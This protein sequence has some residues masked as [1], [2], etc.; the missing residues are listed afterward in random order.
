MPIRKLGLFGNP[1]KPEIAAA[2]AEAAAC[3]RRAGVPLL[4]ASDLAEFAPGVTIVG[5]EELPDRCDVV[6]AFGGDGTMLRAA[7][8]IGHRATPLLGINLGSLG[9]LTDVPSAELVASLDQLFAGAYSVT[10]RTRIRGR[11]RRDG[12]DIVELEA[13]NDLVVNMGPVPRALLMEMRIDQVTL[14]RFLGDG[15]IVSTP[16]GS[17]AYNL[18]AGGPIV[19]PGVRGFVVTP[20][21]PHSLAIRPLLIPEDKTVE[22]RFA[23]V[24][25]GATLTADGQAAYSVASGDVIHYARGEHPVRLV[26]FP[27]SDFFLA[28]RHK[29]QWGA[30][31]RRST[32]E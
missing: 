17:T 12:R 13:L 1:G 10:E 29:L 11:V 4:A 24:G 18:S 9:Y 27:H 3:C 2:V 15:L 31:Q 19:H 28:M 8:T 21:C 6:V 7:R 22:L 23:D 20:I 32:G 26:K 5:E 14:G 25:Q 30:I 16:T